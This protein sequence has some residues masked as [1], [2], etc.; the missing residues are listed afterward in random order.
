MARPSTGRPGCLLVVMT[1]LGAWALAVRP[2][3]A[4]AIVAAAIMVTSW[5]T[6]VA[7]SAGADDSGAPL[8]RFHQAIEA[9]M[10]LH[11]TVEGVLPPSDESADAEDIDVTTEVL[12]SGIRAARSDAVEGEI[13]GGEAAPVFRRAIGDA[14]RDKDC[15]A[16]RI[17]VL[18]RDGERRHVTPRPLIHDEFNWARGSFMPSCI[19]WVLPELPAELQFRL[20]GRDLVIVDLHSNLIVDVLPDALPAG[21]SWRGV[22]YASARLAGTLVM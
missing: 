22:R 7:G 4:G 2:R 5:G 6:A 14:L 12:A 3:T 13:L 10:K 1:A 16:A 20:L 15:D 11:E 21:E 18:E 8:A 9:Y 17:L 19:L